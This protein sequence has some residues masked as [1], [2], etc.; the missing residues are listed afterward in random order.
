[1]PTP[2]KMTPGTKRAIPF[3][4][5]TVLPIPAIDRINSGLKALMTTYSL[6]GKLRLTIA[7]TEGAWLM[8]MYTDSAKPLVTIRNRDIGA[9][10]RFLTECGRVIAKNYGTEATTTKTRKTA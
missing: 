1:M 4:T 7:F 9:L 8:E 5:G 6:T 3:A 2:S 10:N